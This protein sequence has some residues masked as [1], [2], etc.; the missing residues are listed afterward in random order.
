MKHNEWRNNH[1]TCEGKRSFP[2]FRMA[3]EYNNR[4]RTRYFP[5]VKKGKKIEKLHVYRCK[6]C[7]EFHIGHARRKRR[8]SDYSGR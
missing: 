7:N 6:N 1:K 5:R 4:S 2:S 3:S 8:N